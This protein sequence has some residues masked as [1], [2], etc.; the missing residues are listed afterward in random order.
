[1][2]KKCTYGSPTCV[3]TVIKP[4]TVTVLNNV[5]CSK[6]RSWY[7]LLIQCI[8]RSVTDKILYLCVYE[9]MVNTTQYNIDVIRGGRGRVLKHY[10][11]KYVRKW[12]LFKRNRI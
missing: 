7:L 3:K 11:R 8:A 10:Y 6:L 4:M 5:H 9:P 1:L 2:L 12:W